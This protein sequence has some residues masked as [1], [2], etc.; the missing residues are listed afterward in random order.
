MQFETD[1][2]GLRMVMIADDFTG[3]LDTGVKMS[4]HGARVRVVPYTAPEAHAETD[5]LVID[6]ETRHLTAEEAYRRV[7]ALC[8]TFREAPCFYLKT[9][10]ALRGRIGASMKAA[11]DTL[12]LNRAAFAPAY[13]AMNRVTRGGCQLIDGQTLRSSSFAA[14]VLNPVAA[15]SIGEL[16]AGAGLATLGASAACPPPDTPGRAVVVYDAETD[17]DLAAI[18]R[19]LRE[20]NA[21]RLTAGCAGFAE[22][23]A[24]VLGFSLPRQ[25]ASFRPERLMVVCGSLNRVT[26]AQV[27]GSRALGFAQMTFNATLT[28]EDEAWF[29]QARSLMA[30]GRNMVILTSDEGPANSDFQERSRMLQRSGG[31]ALLKMLAMPEMEGYTVMII[32]GDTLMGFMREAGFPEIRIREEVIPGVV[33]FTMTISGRERPFLSKSGGF[34]RDTLFAEILKE[35]GND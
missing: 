7:A 23:L 1:H 17:D 28:V 19:S 31:Q 20:T 11:M 18:A 5:V 21:L 26:R 33:C 35:S 24:P 25:A 9:D 12:G 15:D 8:E 29:S 6:A 3:A 34:G 32:G 27:D 2:T 14:D 30:Q 10:S 16:L 22:A 13:P 4:S